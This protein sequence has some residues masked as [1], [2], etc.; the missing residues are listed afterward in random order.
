MARPGRPPKYGVSGRRI[1]HVALP[2][3]VAHEMELV[4]GDRSWPDFLI[5]MFNVYKKVIVWQEK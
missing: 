4:K 3:D 5:E 1:I 2:V